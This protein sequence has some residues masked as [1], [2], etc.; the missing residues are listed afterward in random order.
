MRAW[1]RRDGELRL[2]DVPEPVPGSDELLLR[3]QA[4][5]LNRGEIRT[6]ARAAEG[7]IPGWDVAGTVVAAARNGKGPAEGARVAGLLGGGGWAELAAVP[8]R[9]AAVVPD[10]VD[11]AVAATLPIAGLTVVRAFDVAGSLAAKRVLVT[12]GSG[13]VGQ[14]AIQL[15]ALAGAE[16]CAVSSRQGQHERLR[17]L[18]ARETVAAIEEATGTFD[19]VLESVGG[20]SLAKAVELVGRG[21]V[22]VSI[23]NSSEQES[24]F[25]AR[26]LYAK[27]AARIYGLL[28]FEEVESGRVGARDLE[29]LLKLVREGRLQAPITLRRDWAELPA[30]MRE[31][32]ER[33][34]TGKAVLRVG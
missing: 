33:A 2:A 11:L 16:V 10:E 21:G 25:N 34:Y 8:A 18:G 22:V 13:G 15:A 28:V 6:A 30:T 27:G 24:T 12:G 14:L 4:V 1:V 29:R 5:S 3:V 23:G 19:L 32:E 20:G 26:T 31:L 7:V 9:Q 17:S